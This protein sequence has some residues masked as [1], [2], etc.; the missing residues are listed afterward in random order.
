MAVF[1]KKERDPWDPPKTRMDKKTEQREP[2]LC[3]CC[4]RPMEEGYLWPKGRGG[5]IWWVSGQIDA[6]S[7]F[8][9]PDPNRALRVDDEGVLFS[10][11]SAALCP[12]CKKI[13]IDAKGLEPPY[14]GTYGQENQ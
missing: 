7:K 11:K 6:K 3:P 10:Y 8:L 4:G 12:D 14:G 13:V 1:E 5:G 9:G 2:T